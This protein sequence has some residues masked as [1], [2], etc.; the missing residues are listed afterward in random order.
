MSS[1]CIDPPSIM[2]KA[3]LTGF[4]QHLH[5]D[6]R[7]LHEYELGSS[8]EIR[9]NE[10]LA[11]ALYWWWP[12]FLLAWGPLPSFLWMKTVLLPLPPCRP[13]Q[14]WR[15]GLVTHIVHIHFEIFIAPIVM[16]M[17]EKKI[18][19]PDTRMQLWTLELTLPL[20][21]VL[22]VY[23]QCSLACEVCGLRTF[24]RVWVI[25]WLVACWVVLESILRACW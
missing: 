2:N 7:W 15:C 3:T 9:E 5:K 20:C 10:P 21:S 19:C 6:R 8:I 18:C 4:P 1:A 14:L 24:P 12:R 17:G 16:L 23:V 11:V 25:A 13:S 22:A